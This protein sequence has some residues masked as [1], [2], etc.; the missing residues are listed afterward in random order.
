MA[1][2]D[3][4]DEVVVVQQQGSPVGPFLWGLG[5]GAALALLFAPMS[6]RELREEIATRGRRLKDV[7]SEKAEEL[8][9]MVRDG[10]DRAR[11]GLEEG[12]GTA[13]RKVR[14]GKE[15]AGDVADASKAAALTAREELERRLADARQARRAGTRT[16][17]EDEP[18]A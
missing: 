2:H 15:L 4:D 12:V 8:E 3:D 7:A 5:I 6:G 16:S 10:Y 11:A 1:R 14:E 9:E 18:V 13:R 17:G